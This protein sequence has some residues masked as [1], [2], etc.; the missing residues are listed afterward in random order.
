MIFIM[1]NTLLLV[2]Y[3]K[4]GNKKGLL[5]QIRAALSVSISWDP[6]LRC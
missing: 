4:N 3:A 5:R 2:T 1:R 6:I